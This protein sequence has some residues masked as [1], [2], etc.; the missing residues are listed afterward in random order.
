MAKTKIGT[1][2]SITVDWASPKAWPRI[3]SWNTATM[4]PNA[5]AVDSRLSSDR[6]D[7]DHQRVEDDQQQQERQAE[8]EREHERDRVEVDLRDVERLGRVARDVGL[9]ARQR[10]EGRRDHRRAHLADRRLGSPG[11]SARRRW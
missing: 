7:R 9:D 6:L 4:T 5:A 2:L 11:R 3:P 1:Q 8:D 10:S